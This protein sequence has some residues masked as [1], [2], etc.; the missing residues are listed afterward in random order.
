[1]ARTKR[2]A[3]GRKLRYGADVIKAYGNE[4]V[5]TEIDCTKPDYE[6][7]LGEALNWANAVFDQK[8]WKRFALEAAKMYNL[9]HDGYAD[10]KDVAFFNVGKLAWVWLG[11]AK[12]SEGAVERYKAR[13][14]AIATSYLHG[15]L[16]VEVKTGDKQISPGERMKLAT[17]S[18][19]CSLD[20]IM[21]DE[22]YQDVALLLRQNTIYPNTV[23]AYYKPHLDE[24]NLIGKDEQV[25]EGYRNWTRKR[26]RLAKEWLEKLLGELDNMKANAKAGRKTRKKKVKT[27]SELVR[28][29]KYLS[30]DDKLNIV[31]VS[32]AEIVGASA[33]LVFNVKY[34]KIEVYQAKLGGVLTIKGTKIMDFEDSASYRK[35]LR[36]PEQ[37]LKTIRSMS[38]FTQVE[39]EIK[40]IKATEQK[41]RGRLSLDTLILKA[42]K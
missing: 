36:K 5:L 23:K 15:P 39:R 26:V 16:Q 1:M 20:K 8:D 3:A 18:V 4:P 11:G 34:R 33:V 28:K 29:V 12:L 22:S 41:C 19:I 9:P 35:T 40:S 17:E 24:L 32:P 10:I 14:N 21:D 37:Q 7:K 38:R 6:S 25:T 27:A 42:F 30:R 2:A 31:S 13:W